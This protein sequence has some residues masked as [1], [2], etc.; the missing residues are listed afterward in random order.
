VNKPSARFPE[1]GDT[2]PV[3]NLSFIIERNYNTCP[4]IDDVAQTLGWKNKHRAFQ[5]LRVTLLTLRDYLTIDEVNH[6]GKQ[7]PIWLAAYYYVGW[8]PHQIHPNIMQGQ[9]RFNL[10]RSIW[11]TLAPIASDAEAK[12]IA[13][14]VIRVLCRRLPE[15]PV[16]TILHKVSRQLESPLNRNTYQRY[17]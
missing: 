7:L 5:A 17:G 15:R 10:H 1:R 3:G 6:L 12:L 9:I 14:A 16:I 13:Q 11:Q 8:Q 2:M 4:W